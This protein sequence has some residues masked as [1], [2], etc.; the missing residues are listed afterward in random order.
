MNNL[1]LLNLINKDLGM[2][3]PKIK[4]IEELESSDLKFYLSKNIRNIRKNL[5]QKCKNKISKGK[6]NKEEVFRL[7]NLHNFLVNKHNKTQVFRKLSEDTFQEL[8]Y[9]EFILIECPN[10]LTKKE[11]HVLLKELSSIGN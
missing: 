2:Y 9:D 4:T 1:E 3:R 8:K 6:I 10:N 5:K 7:I 11:S